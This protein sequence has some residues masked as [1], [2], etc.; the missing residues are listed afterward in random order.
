MCPASL[1]FHL[2][3]A[4]R[5]MYFILMTFLWICLMVGVAGV[6]CFILSE[7]DFPSVYGRGW[8]GQVGLALRELLG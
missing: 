7:V 2:M 3:T 5:S 4:G 6:L 8:R 1:G